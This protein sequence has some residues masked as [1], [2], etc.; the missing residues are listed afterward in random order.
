MGS[1][2]DSSRVLNSEVKFFIKVFLVFLIFLSVNMRNK[3]HF[4]LWWVSPGCMV[5]AAVLS[6]PNIFKNS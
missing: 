1:S 5:A 6:V 3:Y 2:K 4:V